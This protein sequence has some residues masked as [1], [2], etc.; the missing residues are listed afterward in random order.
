MYGIRN[1]YVV[2]SGTAIY[3]KL[4]KDLGDPSNP[5]YVF[6]G[7]G[8]FFSS[9]NIVMDESH[10]YRAAKGMSAFDNKDC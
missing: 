6:K 2:A 5:K 7:I 8:C 1:F 10:H 9:Q 3:D 4:Q